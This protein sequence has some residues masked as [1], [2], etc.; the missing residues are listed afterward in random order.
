[1]INVL[2]IDDHRIVL[3]G[4]KLLLEDINDISVVGEASTLAQAR[5]V[6]AQNNPDVILQD[7]SL[8]RGE[9]GIDFTKEVRKK[10][11]DIKVIALTMHNEQSLIKQMIKN[12][13]SGYVLKDVGKQELV[14][15]IRKVYSGS[16]Y[17]SFSV[18][19]TIM[20]SLNGTTQRPMHLYPK[21]SKREKEILK[22]I[23]EEHTTQEIADKLFLSAGTVETHRRNMLN[24]MGVRNTAGLVR[25]CMEHDLLD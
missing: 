1:M 10:H 9:N 8:K 3:D 15:A 22:L 23:L 20:S 18:Q 14:D 12:G 7:I 4:I 11:P 19:E 21:L 2:I 25:I 13:A 6:I 24:K 17:Y 16:S 5:V